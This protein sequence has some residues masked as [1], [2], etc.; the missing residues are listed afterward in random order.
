VLAQQRL[1]GWR[2]DEVK[3]QQLESEIRLEAEAIQRELQQRHPFYPHSEFVPK[4]DNSKTGYRKGCPCTR[5]VDF[6]STSRDHI[7]WYLEQEGVKLKEKTETGKWQIDESS[8]KKI[9]NPYAAKFARLL[10]LS[11]HLGM[12]SEGQNAWLKLV[13]KDRIHH[14]CVVSTNTH[15]CAHRNPNL[16]QVPSDLRFRDLFIASPGNVLVGADLQAIE[17][18]MLGHY[19]HRYDG[20]RYCEILLN[21]DIHQV[22]ADKIGISRRD[23]KTVTYAFLYGA[24]DEKVGMSIDPTLTAAK[25][26]KLGKQVK[27][28][29]IS[30]IDGLGRL[31]EDV[32][33]AA[34]M[35]GGIKSIDGRFIKV[36]SP[37]KALNYL[38]QSSAGVVAK[39]WVVLSNSNKYVLEGYATQV[40]F[41]HDE[42]VFDVNKLASG[43]LPLLI[44]NSAIT[45]GEFYKLNVPI[46]ATATSG[47][48]WAD[49]H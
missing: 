13:K 7:A 40:G 3:A 10:E 33:E 35:R 42:V 49:I 11:K 8:L 9:T 1:V 43:Q 38:L 14:W 44:E 22:N 39:R 5:L 23:V 18:R 15:R 48:S 45:A 47:H 19:L 29:F 46:A 30:A 27:G 41:I 6:N 28:D 17:L 21:D 31:L 32:K 26:K 2:F 4:R 24:G 25:A 12:L 20:G 36:D 16:A 34:S 37:H